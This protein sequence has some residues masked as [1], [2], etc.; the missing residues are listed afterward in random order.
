M[1]RISIELLFVFAASYIIGVQYCSAT[2]KIYGAS[3][4]KVAVKGVSSV[5]SK[6]ASAFKDTFVPTKNHRIVTDFKDGGH[7]F[8]EIFED[9]KSGEPVTC[10]LLGDRILI[11]YLL[12]FIPSGLVTD[13][14]VD[15]M[16]VF[17]D[18][19]VDRESEEKGSSLLDLLGTAFKSLLIYPG[20]KWC[21]AG[22]IA[23]SYNDLGIIREIDMCCRDHDHANDSIPAFDTKHGITNFRFYTMTNCDDDER[24]FKCLVDASNVVTASVGIAY[25]DVLKTKCFKYGHPLRCTG[26]N[27]FRMLRLRSP[28]NNKEE[29]TSEPKSWS[30]QNPTNFLE[31]FVNRKKND[32][33]DAIAGPEAN[34]SEY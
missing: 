33:K 16:D 26:F 24:F 31:A 32:L 11:K 19:C 21:G 7:R 22:D 15:E 2:I 5:V 27:P 1:L 14:T 20:T 25:F 30:V 6:A 17:I 13:V 10:N 29:D 28:C 23:K 9:K 4:L 12:K 3:P 8:A 34:D 18:K